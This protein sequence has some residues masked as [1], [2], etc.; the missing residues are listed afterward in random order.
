MKQTNQHEKSE[1]RAYSGADADAKVRDF[2]DRLVCLGHTGMYADPHVFGAEGYLDTSCREN[3]NHIFERDPNN[4]R[5][6]LEH[7][8][9]ERL[10]ATAT[11]LVIRPGPDTNQRVIIGQSLVNTYEQV[12]AHFLEGKHFGESLG[13]KI[14]EFEITKPSLHFSLDQNGDSLLMVD[15]KNWGKSVSDTEEYTHG[16]FPNGSQIICAYHIEKTEPEG[17]RHFMSDRSLSKLRMSYV[18]LGKE[19]GRR[20]MVRYIL[21]ATLAA[22]AISAA[23]GYLLAN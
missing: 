9:S 23:V 17:K 13:E 20:E 3:F 8:V 21:P 18:D 19:M 4:R 14:E 7:K 2:V 5:E 6:W 11:S 16:H 12:C 1:F 22:G 10:P 15:K